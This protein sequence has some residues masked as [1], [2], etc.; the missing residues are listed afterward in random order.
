[1]EEILKYTYL[2]DSKKLDETL[3]KM[4]E[5]YQ[6]I[7]ENPNWDDLNEARAILYVIGYL[8]PEQI[9]PEAIKRRLHLLSE[10]LEELDFYQ[11]VDSKNKDEQAKRKN[12]A[13]FLEM[14]EYYKVVKSFKNKTNKGIWYLDEDRFVEIYNKYS[15]DQSMK[16]GRFGEFDKDD[17]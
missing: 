16:I 6:H 3:T 4:W 9:A 2:L 1:M 14:V 5:R 11:I 10:P 17:K 13:L 7:L 8:F 15:P 12:D